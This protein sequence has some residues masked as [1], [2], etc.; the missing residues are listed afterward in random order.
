MSQQNLLISYWQLPQ[1][2]YISLIPDFHKEFCSIIQNKLNCKYKHCFHL[3]FNCPKWKAKRLFNRKVR[4]TIE[5][6]E[7]LRE[8]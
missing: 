4:F 8:I 3:I 1:E 5:K 7:I 2:I 6:L